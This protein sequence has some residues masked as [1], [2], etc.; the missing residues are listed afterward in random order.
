M[1]KYWL[2]LRNS[3]QTSFAYRANFF[4]RLFY[5]GLALVIFSYVWLSLYRSGGSMGEYTLSS[6][7]A[8]YL[9]SAFIRILTSGGD[10]GWVIGDEIREGRI[11][12]VLLVPI[13][14]YKMNLAKYLGAAVSNIIVF[15]PVFLF[16]N[17]FFEF[18]FLSWRILPFFFLSLATGIMVDFT[19]GYLVGI[20]TFYFGTV[21]GFNFLVS[22]FI[23]FFSGMIIP[24]NLLPRFWQVI[25]DFLPFKY[26]N[27]FPN[28]VINSK[29]S[30]LEMIHG[31]LLGLAWVGLSLFL[32]R[33]VYVRGLK[34]FE[35][36]GI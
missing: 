8:Y 31:S 4:A 7:L 18:T 5:E 34:R 3:L 24:L 20:S 16:I 35:G 13:S 23:R 17:L 14:H 26:I 12:T 32:M 19:V 6:L 27:Y 2:I 30:F 10:M 11:S 9:T 36:E 28:Q 22:N 21:Q 29:L 1:K 25:A 15:L 33:V